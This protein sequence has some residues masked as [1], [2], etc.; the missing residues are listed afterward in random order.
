MRLDLLLDLDK[1]VLHKNNY[2]I[3]GW[4]NQYR[5]QSEIIFFN[6]LELF[7]LISIYRITSKIKKN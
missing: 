7:I 1:E 5:C 4:I 6:I 2:I 3:K